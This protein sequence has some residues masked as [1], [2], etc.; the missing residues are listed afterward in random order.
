M[1]RYRKSTVVLLS[2][3]IAVFVDISVSTQ[4]ALKK[5]M[6]SLCF[7]INYKQRS[8]SCGDRYQCY[9]FQRMNYILVFNLRKEKMKTKSYT[10]TAYKSMYYETILKGKHIIQHAEME[11]IQLLRFDIIPYHFNFNISL[12][13]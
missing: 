9:R 13:I 3:S 7:G 12:P 10:I 8:I 5:I 11:S 1:L 6:L 4:F 2:T